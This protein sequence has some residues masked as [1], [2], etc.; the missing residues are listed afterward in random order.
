[1]I[2]CLA[3]NEAKDSG[4]C[5]VLERFRIQTCDTRPWCEWAVLDARLYFSVERELK[6]TVAVK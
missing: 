4:T 2:E 3:G 6:S 1:M 5:V